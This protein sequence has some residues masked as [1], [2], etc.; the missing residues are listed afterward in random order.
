[1]QQVL[2]NLLT[3]AMKFTPSGGRVVVELNASAGTARI[4]V[5]DSGDGIDPRVLP[6]VFEPFVKS[7]D[8]RHGLGLGLA[9]VRQMVEMH[10]G[11]V[12]V[13]DPGE[14]KGACLHLTLPLVGSVDSARG[15]TG[16]NERPRASS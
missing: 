3:N 11:T 13:E 10:G 4:S 16:W 9:I 5:A 2:M 1:L 8:S 14:G 15:A 7:Q 6:R 12:G